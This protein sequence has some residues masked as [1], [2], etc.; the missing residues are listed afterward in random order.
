[1][2]MIDNNQAHGILSF[3]DKQYDVV[4][5]GFGKGPL[6]SGVY[7]VNKPYKMKPE[8][9]KT[10]AFQRTDFPWVSKLNP[11]FET[12]RSGLYIHPDGNLPGTQ[13]CIGILEDDT[14]CFYDLN[15]LFKN[16]KQ[17]TLEV[18]FT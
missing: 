3:N 10:E 18:K 9:G 11:L 8:K 1:M 5:G 13:G 4:T 15:N 2:V 6:P 7:Q 16:N 14:Q 17:I 12:D